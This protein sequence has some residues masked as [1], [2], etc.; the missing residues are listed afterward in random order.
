MRQ[1]W[2]PPAHHDPSLSC[3]PPCGKEAQNLDQLLPRLLDAISALVNDW[4][5]I[6]VDDGSN[7][8]TPEVLARWTREDGVRAIQLSRDF[9]K[10]D[11]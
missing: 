10:S 8:G 9:G 11:A 4:E 1:T 3:I 2:T 7:D 5:V 6:I